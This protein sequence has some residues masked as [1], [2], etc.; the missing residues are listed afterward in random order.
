MKPQVSVVLIG[1]V[2]A[3]KSTLAGN[4]LVLTNQVDERLLE[5]C[6]ELAKN[7][8]RP[9]WY[10][11]YLLDVSD[12]ERSRG[13]T[14]NLGRC[15]FESEI[16]RYTILDAPGHRQY[17]PNMIEGVTQADI[18]VLIISAR[19]GEF[20][21]GF[22]KDGQTREHL[23]LC[24][25][26]GVTKVVVAIN[27]MDDSTVNWN[28]SRYDDI[29]SKITMY[30]KSLK[31]VVNEDLFFVPVSGYS[32]QNIL[33]S[34]N[35]NWYFGPTLVGLLD[36]LKIIRYTE[37]SPV[38]SI[39]DRC[40]ENG[41]IYITCKILKGT[42]KLNDELTI[43]PGERKIQ[44]DE[45]NTI[46]DMTISEASA[47]ETIIVIPKNIEE[48]EIHPGYVLATRPINYQKRL[49]AQIKFLN[50]LESNPIFTRGSKVMMHIHSET[51]LVT[52]HQIISVGENG[53]TNTTAFCKSKDSAVIV[54]DCERSI[55]M[56][57]NSMLPAL[58]RFTLREEDSTIAVGRIIS[59]GP[60]K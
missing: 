10:L 2:D 29:C 33:T 49:V 6:K 40:K 9:S 55:C 36:S 21:A 31:Y 54:L 7:N 19:T 12:E 53:P 32:G 24:K 39:L 20:E 51:V 13:K 27:K 22:D 50:L 48:N 1:H 11:A 60:K 3:G 16:Y 42:I 14:I 17:V 58:C 28:Q 5:K 8:Y 23:L 56:S 37:G 30:A 44:L 47:G 18:A 35:D 26:F 43:Y 41:K 25:T 45:L 46:E 57:D 34:M 15:Q 4:L 38:L 59:L 52:C